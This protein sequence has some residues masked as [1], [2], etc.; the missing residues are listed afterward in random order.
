[1]SR[2]IVDS[3]GWLAYFS[4]EG[5]ADKFAPHI[6]GDDPVVVPSIVEYEVY[7]WALRE[8]GEDRALQYAAVL[9]RGVAAPV[10]AEAA[11]RAAEIG[12]QHKLAACD[13][14]ILAIAE[15][16]SVPL[17]TADEDL[18]YLPG[19]VFHAKPTRTGESPKARRAATR[20]PPTT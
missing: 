1:V 16:L 13:A 8:L 19:V 4:D 3:C 18:R 17:V 12:H 15:H 7:R 20:K 2:V 14:M 6:E 9:S 5:H 10:T 11:R